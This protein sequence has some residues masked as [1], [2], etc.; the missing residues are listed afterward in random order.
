MSNGYV[1]L[2]VADGKCAGLYKIGKANNPSKRI[3]QFT[4]MPFS[5]RLIHM[6]SCK[7]PKIVE[8][9]LHDFFAEFRS[10]GEWFLLSADQVETITSC[11]DEEELLRLIK[12]APPSH[13]SGFR[14]GRLHVVL[15]EVS[16]RK[17]Y[18][19]Y[20]LQK[21]TGLDAGLVRRYW[22]NKTTSIDLRYLDRLCDYLGV[23]IGDILEHTPT[24]TPPVRHS[25]E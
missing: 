19:M 7:N 5:I 22:H 1:Y 15:K 20:Q 6:I 16:E 23:A 10:G 18:S 8:S 9:A 2:V 25:V 3:K 12:P 11:L 17:G 14:D 4:H 24:T 21:E 13:C